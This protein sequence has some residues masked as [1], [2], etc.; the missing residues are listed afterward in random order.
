MRCLCLLLVVIVSGCASYVTPG[1]PANLT[2]VQNPAMADLFLAKPAASFPARIVVARVQAANYRSYQGDSVLQAPTY[3][4]ITTQQLLSESQLAAIGNWPLLAGIAPLSRLLLP[5]Q[6]ASFEDLRMS[7][8]RLQAD[9][10]LVYTLDTGFQVQGRSYGA[11][12]AISL[13]IIPDRDAYI[14]STASALF[15][16]VRTGFV[17]GVAEATAKETSLTNIWGE[18]STIDRKRVETEQKA[19][20]QLVIEAGKT[21]AGISKPHQAAVTAPTQH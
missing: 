6:L 10:L 16:D 15:I 11:L 18:S 12:S 14:T 20:D 4:L 1:G 2:G 5:K 7:A 17:H 3:S 9:I 19:F 21:W 8:A 13:G